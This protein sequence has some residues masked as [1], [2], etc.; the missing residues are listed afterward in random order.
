MGI[1]VGMYLNPFLD[2]LLGHS[3][4]NS[5]IV[6]HLLSLATECSHCAFPNLVQFEKSCAVRSAYLSPFTLSLSPTAP[7]IT[8]PV[9]P[10]A[11]A[12]LYALYVRGERSPLTVGFTL[13]GKKSIYACI[14][15]IHT[16]RSA[17]QDDL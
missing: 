1:R 12:A 9:H 13:R 6:F 2:S 4:I 17:C 16:G 5:N 10:W 3:H 8:Y 7:A 14:T 15:L 11:L